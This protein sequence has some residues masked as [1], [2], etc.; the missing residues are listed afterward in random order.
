MVWIV[1]E[2]TCVTAHTEEYV[3]FLDLVFVAAADSFDIISPFFVCSCYYCSC[4]TYIVCC[5]ITTRIDIQ[6]LVIFFKSHQFRVPI[7]LL[8]SLKYDLMSGMH[9][10]FDL[11]VS[12]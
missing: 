4:S 11:H 12:V 2:R 10:N 3:I 1:R 9:D 8:H 5:L 7:W 6:N